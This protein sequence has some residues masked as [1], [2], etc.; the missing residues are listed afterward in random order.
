[1]RKAYL[2]EDKIMGDKRN[3]SKKMLYVKIAANYVLAAVLLLATIFLMPRLIKFM[4]PFVA[5]WISDS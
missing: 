1:M 5:G 4:W 2:W 3:N